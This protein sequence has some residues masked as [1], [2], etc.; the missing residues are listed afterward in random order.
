MEKVN[1]VALIIDESSK[2]HDAG[3]IMHDSSCKKYDA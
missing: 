3:Y 1:F 2:M